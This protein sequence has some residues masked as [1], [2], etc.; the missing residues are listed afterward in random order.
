MLSEMIGLRRQ[1]V[2][3]HR[4][5]CVWLYA[6]KYSHTSLIRSSFIRIPRHPEENSWLQVYSIHDASKKP[7]GYSCCPLLPRH[8]FNQIQQQLVTV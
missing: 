4:F 1:V 6:L 8:A 2:F 5:V 7:G 3:V